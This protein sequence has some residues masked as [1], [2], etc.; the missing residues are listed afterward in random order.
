MINSKVLFTVICLGIY[1]TA[2]SQTRSINIAILPVFG[3][4]GVVLADS[5]FRV[6]DVQIDVLKFYISGVRLLQNGDVV[7]EEPNSFH[8]VDASIDKPFV[9]AIENEQDVGF[10]ELKFNLGIDSASSVLGAMGGDLDP[11]KGMYWTWQSG[12]VNFKL[13]GKSNLCKTNDNKFEFH[14]GGYQQPFV[15][16]QTLAFP[17]QNP[18][19]ISV[20]VDVE[21][22][23]KHIDL[24]NQNRVMSPSEEAV[25]LSKLV[26]N[27]FSIINR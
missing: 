24:E 18:H 7:I 5:A 12:Y 16:L 15:C 2:L 11:T 25:I 17:V 27:S 20:T 8:L 26:A 22:L 1:S 9:L 19:Q 4:Q 6:E 21:K 13:E 10:D 23:L 3:S 14:L